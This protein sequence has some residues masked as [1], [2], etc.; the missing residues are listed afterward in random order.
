MFFNKIHHNILGFY[1]SGKT[2]AAVEVVKIKAALQKVSKQ[3]VEVHALVFNEGLNQLKSD[4]SK[5][6]FC[7]YNEAHVTVTDLKEYIEKFSKKYQLKPEHQ[8][9]LEE[10]NY[11]SEDF[12]ITL[13]SLA[14]LLNMSGKTHIILM[15]EV[16][17]KNVTVQKE[18]TKE[19][20]KNNIELDLSYLSEY[21]NVH[22]ILS[23]RPAILGVNNFSL[24]FPLMQSNQH[25]CSL[26]RSY[27]N[28]EA[29]QRLIQFFQSQI[30]T[31]AEGYALMGK[32][33]S[34]DTLPRPLVPSCYNSCVIWVPTI[35]SIEDEALDKISD[36]LKLKQF[37]YNQDEE[38][39]SIAILHTNKDSKT[40][41]RKLICKNPNW[42]G[43]HE[44]VNYNGGEADVVVFISDGHI[45]V[46]TLARAR[47]MLVIL[48]M[49]NEWYYLR[50]QIL[51]LKKAIALD[52]AD[53]MRFADCPYEMISCEQ[54]K[55]KFDEKSIYYHIL[56]QCHFK[57]Q[58]HRKGCEWKGLARLHDIHLKKECEHE[59]A[60]CPNSL[61]GCEWEGLAKMSKNHVEICKWGLVYCVYCNE[62][63]HRKDTCQHESH[64]CAHLCHITKK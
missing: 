38:N 2:L 40:L 21:E 55:S 52:I 46:Q 34:A 64:Y 3:E 41:A 58:N 44:D 51:T 54:C 30:D 10:Y 60:T 36:L 53:I 26:G 29:I 27:R 59:Y 61:K 15:D 28:T 43:P 35:P 12:K 47:R 49:E 37:D 11:S 48:T 18:S 63:L 42:S 7:D 1:G 14:N 57:C 16:D 13:K 33:P 22:F 24:S 39:L 32:I 6:L 4:I 31:K 8:S 5:K 62:I 20:N 9:Q 45:N 50:N 17:L 23:L 19:R 25:Y 56:E